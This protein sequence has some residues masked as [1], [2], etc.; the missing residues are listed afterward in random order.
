MLTNR[1]RG[2]RGVKDKDRK[3]ERESN[4]R[5]YDAFPPY[6]Y[7]SIKTV[8]YSFPL[9][10]HSLSV[11]SSATTSSPAS[12]SRTQMSASK[13]PSHTGHSTAPTPPGAVCVTTRALCASESYLST[14]H[15]AGDVFTGMFPTRIE[16]SKNSKVTVQLLKQIEEN[17]SILTTGMG[18]L[19]KEFNT[20]V[21]ALRKKLDTKGEKVYVIGVTTAWH[22]K[23][24]DRLN[25]TEKNAKTK[26]QLA[27][28][29]GQLTRVV[30]LLIA[31]VVADWM[32]DVYENHK[33]IALTDYFPIDAQ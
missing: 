25:V 24:C 11:I 17:P 27:K 8:S 19:P 2:G 21:A 4:R 28:T 1:R 3:I 15:G 10:F 6:L 29:K 30:W 20:R 22:N 16:T 7:Y 12:T 14:I 32:Y 9:L 26:G 23:V 18:K 13:L 33:K 31:Y 5:I